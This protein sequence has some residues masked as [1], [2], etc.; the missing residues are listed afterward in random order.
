MYSIN[1]LLF[2]DVLLKKQVGFVKMCKE[3]NGQPSRFDF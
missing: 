3:V 2:V 1:V